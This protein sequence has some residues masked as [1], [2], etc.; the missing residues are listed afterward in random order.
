[1]RPDYASGGKQR[2]AHLGEGDIHAPEKTLD[3]PQPLAYDPD[4]LVYTDGSV[5]KD[6]GEGTSR[7]RGAEG[8][9]IAM[10]AGVYIPALLGGGKQQDIAIDPR[11]PAQPENDTINR[12]ELSAI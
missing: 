11:D 2:P 5:L 8:K 1:M 9:T 4:S 12:A 7:N 10:G 6:T 3:P